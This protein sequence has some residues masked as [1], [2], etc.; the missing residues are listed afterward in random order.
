MAEIPRCGGGTLSRVE[1]VQQGVEFTAGLLGG[2]GVTEE[3]F[4]TKAL[5]FGEPLL[6]LRREHQAWNACRARQSESRS[7]TLS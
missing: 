1:F 7:S 2:E 4:V 6:L 5:K 3:G